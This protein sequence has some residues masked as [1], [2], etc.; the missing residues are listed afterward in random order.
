MS[1]YAGLRTTSTHPLD[2]TAHTSPSVTVNI[3]QHTAQGYSNMTSSV[4][5][6]TALSN[7]TTVRSVTMHA[8]VHGISSTSSVVTTTAK[9]NAT[10]LL[11]VTSFSGLW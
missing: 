9:T 7:A 10:F 8:D 1:Y 6:S 11:S 4:V 2:V 5:L 3:R